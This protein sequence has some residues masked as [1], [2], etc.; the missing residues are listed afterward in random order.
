MFHQDP[1]EITYDDKGRQ[2]VESMSDRQLLEETVKWQRIT[3]DTLEQMMQS[4]GNN[5]MLKV[6]VGRFGG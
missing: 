4:M 5:P 6:L 3:G 1:Q 2:N